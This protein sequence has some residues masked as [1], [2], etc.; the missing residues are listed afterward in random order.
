[1]RIE[2]YAFGRI[3]VEGRT[4][5]HDLIIFPDRIEPNWRRRRNH[6]LGLEDLRDVLPSGPAFLVVGRGAHRGMHIPL[7]T[8]VGLLDH[9]LTLVEGDSREM[10]RVFNHYLAEGKHTVGAFHLTC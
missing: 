1:M 5:V 3:V 4:Y 2:D 8:E 10:C 9:R 6:R 7:E